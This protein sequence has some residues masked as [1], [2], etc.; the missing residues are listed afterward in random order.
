MAVIDQ[1]G[2]P[3]TA[4]T[5]YKAASTHHKA[6]SLWN[7]PLR[8][9][10]DATREKRPIEARVLDAVRNNPFVAG[11]VRS[12]VDTIVGSRFRLA[13]RPDYK[14][15]G[16][17]RAA[18]KQW[19]SQVEGEWDA[20]AENPECWIDVRREMTFSDMVRMSIRMDAIHGE[21]FVAKEWQTSPIGYKTCFQLIDPLRVQAENDNERTRNGIERTEAG[22]PIAYHIKSAG[23][24]YNGSV[25]YRRIPKYNRFGWQQFFHVFDADRP[26]QSR[27]ISR[28]ASALSTIK[29]LDRYTETEL[30]MAILAASY[31]L[32]IK[33]DR[34][35]VDQMF[36][37]GAISPQ[38]RQLLEARDTKYKNMP[39]INNGAQ[40]MHMMPGEEI[41][42]VNI[43]HPTSSYDGFT[44][45]VSRG[46]ARGIGSSYEQL[47][48]DF[49]RTSYSSARASLIEAQR[50]VDAKRE[51]I[52]GRFATTA[53]RIWL[54]EAVDKGRVNPPVD[55]W[56]NRAA[57]TRCAWI[58]TGKSHIDELKTA[59]AREVAKAG[60]WATLQQFAAEDGTDWEEVLEQRMIEA[61]AFIDAIEGQGMTLTNEQKSKIMMGELSGNAVAPQEIHLDNGEIAE[62]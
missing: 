5:E 16:V 8:D 50:F 3:M 36:D 53:F 49:S 2:R 13:L 59:R 37:G 55:Y 35:D 39:F 27:G 1:Y 28:I 44:T 57:L 54:D 31:A 45:S 4:G 33:S 20:Y 61:E 46:I 32:Y 51:T 22:V 47:T 60:G 42:T 25:N 41:G 29:Q 21:A 24:I 40:V 58:S 48:G 62:V 11:A 9:G 30:E 52:A 15:I 23:G 18:S 26:G 12:Q 17:D 14:L 7:P 10:D 19:V 38:Y 34:V 43:A 56:Q 6:V